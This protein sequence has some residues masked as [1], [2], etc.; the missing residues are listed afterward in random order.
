MEGMKNCV[1][2][3]HPFQTFLLQTLETKKFEK[4]FTKKFHR[5][6]KLP[7]K[8]LSQKTECDRRIL[9]LQ[10]EIEDKLHRKLFEF[11]KR[12]HEVPEWEVIE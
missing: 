2:K 10:N 6:E 5:I 4:L 9:G 7:N 8:V 1:Q 12:L 11:P 3:V